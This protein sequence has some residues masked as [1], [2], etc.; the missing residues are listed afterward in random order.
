MT[1][2]RLAG[3]FDPQKLLALRRRR[4][5]SLRQFGAKIGRSGASIKQIEDGHAH[6]SMQ[7]VEK[8]AE[9]FEMDIREFFI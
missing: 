8:I 9:V 6:P 1:K 2:K 7:T 5:L 3:R 4:G